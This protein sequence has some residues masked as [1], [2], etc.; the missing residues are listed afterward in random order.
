MATQST[1]NSSGEILDFY[2]NND[3]KYIKNVST[4]ITEGTYVKLPSQEFIFEDYSAV[5]VLEAL[6]KPQFYG[7]IGNNES[8][9]LNFDYEV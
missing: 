4:T 6:A 8:I 7:Y 2:G 1:F 3:Y 5:D 9:E